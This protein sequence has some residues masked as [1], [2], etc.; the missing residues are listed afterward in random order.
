MARRRRR[1]KTSASHVTE[2]KPR[3]FGG[4]MCVQIPIEEMR[5]DDY[6]M[7]WDSGYRV[8][9]VEKNHKGYKH[10]WVKLYPSLW[11]EH[12]LRRSKKIKPN[13][14]RSVWRKLTASEEGTS[15]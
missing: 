5:K 14:I 1:K 6:I 9:K 11:K 10:R 15:S 12:V 3:K 13:L 8:A 2:Q 7:Y 4:S